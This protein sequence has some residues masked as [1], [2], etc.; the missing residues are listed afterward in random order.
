MSTQEVC[1]EIL[2]SVAA[3]RANPRAVASRIRQRLAYYDGKQFS[4]PAVDGSSPSKKVTKEGTAAVLDAVNFLEQQAA[5][6]G[7]S[8]ENIVGLA[9]CGDDH[10]EDVGAEGVASHVGSDGCGCWDRMARYGRWDGAC[11]ECLWYGRVGPHL[12]GETIVDDLIVDDG[13][14]SRGHRLAIFD[15]R[16]NVAGVALGLHKTYG[17][18]VAIELA[19]T[20]CNDDEAI[21]ARV[22]AGAPQLNKVKGVRAGEQR[23]QWKLGKCKGCSLDIEGGRVVEAAGGKWHSECFCCTQCQESLLGVKQKKEENG[24]IFCQAC[25]VELYAPTCCVCTQKISGER[26]KKGDTYRHP[27][28]RSSPPAAFK[29]HPPGSRLQGVS[30]MRTQLPP[31]TPPVAGVAEVRRTTRS[32]PRTPCCAPAA[33]ASPRLLNQVKGVRAGE[34]ASTNRT[35]RIVAKYS[36]TKKGGEKRGAT[37]R[38][39]TVRGGRGAEVKVARKKPAKVPKPCFAGAAQSLNSMAMGYGELLMVAQ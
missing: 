34:L 31:A 27:T 4:P 16:Y 39:A 33:S 20:Y 9:L 37:V 22:K 36:V 25:W 12:N 6:P 38:G 11:G 3:A 28:C 10:V 24:R 21:K 19:G 7:F 23:T 15:E 1:Q 30:Q 17:N 18:M 29:S 8:V 5:L 14:P 35:E 26:V 2:R 13:V 32:P